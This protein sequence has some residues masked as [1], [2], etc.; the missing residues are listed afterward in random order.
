MGSPNYFYMLRAPSL[1]SD[2]VNFPIEIVPN[3]W[4]ISEEPKDQKNSTNE[5]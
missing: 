3:I 4:N 1:T 5:T 2:D